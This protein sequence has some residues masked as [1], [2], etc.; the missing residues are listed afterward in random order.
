MGAENFAFMLEAR[1]GAII[2]SDNGDTAYCH[3]PDHDFN[4]EIIPVGISYWL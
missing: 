3:N 4:D 1:P 2:N